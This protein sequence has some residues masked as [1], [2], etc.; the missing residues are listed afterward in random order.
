MKGIDMKLKNKKEQKISPTERIISDKTNF[1][2]I[3]TLKSIRTNIMFSIPK[4]DEGKV[5]VVT[6][7]SPS[8]GKTTTC[9]NLA[10]T[11]AQMGAKVLLIDCDLRKSRV[12]RYLQLERKDGVTNILCGFTDFESAVKRNVRENLDVLTSGETPPN[13]AELF[14][15]EVFKAMLEQVQKEY[16]YIIIDTPPLAVVTDA[17]V[18]MKYSTGVVMIV[19]RNVTTFDLLDVAMDSIAKTGARL[20]GA[21]MLGVEPK[22]KRYGYYRKLGY[23]YSY[24]YK[25]SWHYG[26]VDSTTV[27]K[28]TKNAR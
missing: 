12:H 13:P 20:L 17:A 10:I 1:D 28:E 16:E 24:S 2:T 4:S 7:S 21:V 18:I 27:S 23:K 14:E 3:E 6:S 8:E 22:T 19:H 15:N 5:I 11:F 25:N 9:T 26:D